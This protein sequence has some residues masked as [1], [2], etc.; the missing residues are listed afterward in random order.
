MNSGLLSCHAL[1]TS[2]SELVSPQI[3]N[4]SRPIRRRSLPD[5]D[6]RV[7]SFSLLET[8]EIDL[9]TAEPVFR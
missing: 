6:N 7:R 8:T 3:Q 2:V 1:Q 4:A 5:T 9:R